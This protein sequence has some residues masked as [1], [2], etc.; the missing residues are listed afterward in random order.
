MSF[1][2]SKTCHKVF[3]KEVLG[4][5]EK[6]QDFK[7]HLIFNRLVHVILKLDLISEYQLEDMCRGG[8]KVEWMHD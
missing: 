6:Y 2:I 5:G 4:Y 8:V 3:M 7:S 1:F